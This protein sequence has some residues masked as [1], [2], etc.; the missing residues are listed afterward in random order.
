L[1]SFGGKLWNCLHSKI[2]PEMIS[3]DAQI[4]QGDMSRLS[5]WHWTKQKLLLTCLCMWW[6]EQVAG[7]GTKALVS[8]PATCSFHHMHRFSMSSIPKLKMSSIW[9]AI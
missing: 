3:E 9:W 7:S 4:F 8:D 1:A 5:S 6:K 2:A